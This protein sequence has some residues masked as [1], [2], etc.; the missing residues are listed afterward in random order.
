MLTFNFERETEAEKLKSQ[1]NPEFTDEQNKLMDNA[2]L[3][4]MEINN[5]LMAKPRTISKDEWLDNEAFKVAAYLLFKI[6]KYNN[7]F[8]VEFS[9]LNELDI[10]P[11]IVNFADQAGISV[12]WKELRELVNRYTSDILRLT[13]ALNR[14]DADDFP[15]NRPESISTLATSLLDIADGEDFADL[16]CEDGRITSKIKSAC[17]NSS[18]IGFDSNPNAIALAKIQSEVFNTNIEYSTKDVFTLAEDTAHAPSFKK[19]LAQYP[20]RVRNRELG[21]IGEYWDNYKKRIPSISRATSSDWIHNLLLV[22][23]LD[24]NGKAVG[25]MANGS[26]WNTIDI[27]IRQYF[28]ENGFIEAVINLPARIFPLH[29]VGTS[30]ILLS[31]GNKGIR[32]INATEQYEAGR[33]INFITEENINNILEAFET[34][35]NIS[36][37]VSIEEIRN[38][39][40]SLHSLRYLKEQQSIKDGVLFGDVI[41]RITRGAPLNAKELDELASSAPTNVQYLTLSNIHDGLIDRDLPYINEIDKKLDKYC[42]TNHCIILSKN[43]APYKVAVAELEKGQ[44]VLANGNLYIIEIDEEQVDPYYLT[45]FLASEQ[46]SVALKNISVGSVIPNVG[47]EQLKKVVIPLPDMETQ[48][49]I[50]QRYRNLKDEVVLLQLKLEKVR[51]HIANLFEEGENA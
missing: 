10:D 5:I 28:V 9:E 16:F 1:W 41:K 27:P 26:T 17:P 13:V 45:A 47:V 19:I 40:Y 2:I 38:N 44:K 49:Q 36:R 23:L 48:K 50:A 51:S 21:P 46:G 18:V 11:E 42:L 34:D 20:L 24:D 33:R 15:L 39:E 32:L 35:S 3:C 29:S 7:P 43:G 31:K 30:M 4:M 8:S 22:D 14:I 12:V 25:I 37:F 6:S